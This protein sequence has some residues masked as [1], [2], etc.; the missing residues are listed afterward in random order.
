MPLTLTAGGM[1]AIQGDSSETAF[2]TFKVSN[3][4][5]EAFKKA[6]E[7]KV[8]KIVDIRYEKAGE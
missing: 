1:G 4:E 3:I 2:V 5:L 6:L 7:P 8:E